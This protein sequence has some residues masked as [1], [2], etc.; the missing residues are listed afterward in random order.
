MAPSMEGLILARFIAGLGGGGLQVSKY[1]S[2]LSR[3]LV[4]MGTGLIMLC[5]KLPAPSPQT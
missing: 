1:N 4:V 2:V 3:R 5:F